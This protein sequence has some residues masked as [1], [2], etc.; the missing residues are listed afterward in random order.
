MKSIPEGIIVSKEEMKVHTL[1]NGQNQW[2]GNFQQHIRLY[3]GEYLPSA[4]QM[5]N[6]DVRFTMN[7]DDRE[8]VAH[9]IPSNRSWS[10]VAPLMLGFQQAMDRFLATASDESVDP[11]I[12]EM[13]QGFQLPS[14]VTMP[15]AWRIAQGSKGPRLLVLWGFESNAGDGKTYSFLPAGTG[16]SIPLENRDKR[17]FAPGLVQES[18]HK[19][20]STLQKFL[21][22]LL[23]VLLALL[24]FFIWKLIQVS[25]PSYEVSVINYEPLENGQGARCTLAVRSSTN[26]PLPRSVE[27]LVDGTPV[28][29]ETGPELERQ[30][31]PKNHE[32]KASF[33]V[34]GKNYTTSS[35]LFVCKGTNV[36]VIDKRPVEP[37]TNELPYRLNHEPFDITDDHQI[38]SRFSIDSP[39]GRPL[40]DSVAWDVDGNSLDKQE[41]SVEVTLPSGFHRINAH[42]QDEIGKEYD[43]TESGEFLVKKD[44]GIIVINP[45]I[46]LSSD[47]TGPVIPPDSI[48]VWDGPSTEDIFSYFGIKVTYLGIEDNKRVCSFELVPLKDYTADILSWDLD[49]E[50]LKT[51]DSQIEYALDEGSHRI[52]VNFRAQNANGVKSKNLCIITQP[53]K[54]SAVKENEESVR[55][56][57]PRIIIEPV[58]GRRPQEKSI[59]KN[60][61]SQGGV[62]TPNTGGGVDSGDDADGPNKPIIIDVKDPPEISDEE[63]ADYFKM[64]GYYNGIEDGKRVFSF[65]LVPLQLDYSAEVFS[66]DVDGEVQ[67]TSDSQIKLA[68]DT[69]LHKVTA[70]FHIQNSDGSQLTKSYAISKLLQVS[71]ISDEEP[72]GGGETIIDLGKFKVSEEDGTGEIIIIDPETIKDV[73]PPVTS[74]PSDE[75]S[76]IFDLEILHISNKNGK[77]QF[78]FELVPLQSYRAKVLNWRIDEKKQMTDGDVITKSAMIKTLTPGLHN[79]KVRYEIYDENGR[80]VSGDYSLGKDFE[81]GNIDES[82]IV[83]EVPRKFVDKGTGRWIEDTDRPS[84]EGPGSDEGPEE[85][86][87]ERGRGTVSVGSFRLSYRELE[88]TPEGSKYSFMIV[89]EDSLPSGI[90]WLVD[91]KQVGSGETLE[92]FLEPGTHN[93]TAKIPSKDGKFLKPTVSFT[94]K[95]VTTEVEQ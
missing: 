50:V 30:F 76:R 19:G 46:N 25:S 57:Q 75:L 2:D 61:F 6:G 28:P 67:E 8:I 15:E 56:E 5:E 43:L 24:G 88:N 32:V 58:P 52:T 72:I 55:F 20:F 44:Q 31:D 39:S 37:T 86:P 45:P 14:P 33:A 66:W 63:L 3:L 42:F 60:P 21:G 35:N 13:V 26:S 90:N 91:D 38:I 4:V 77:G 12:R 41:S 1:R 54:C 81:V 92:Y 78:Q 17:L 23:I 47:P 87:I 53:L 94:V 64:K 36:L 65:E 85:K 10:A 79:V 70:N 51:S 62:D 49:G 59:G 68:V 73:W 22:L 69:G 93:V 83:Y 74:I 11:T 80:R 9:S 29:E 7:D 82:E 18:G 84:K 48:D 71:A 34:K 16:N 95:T 40:P 27:W 89:S